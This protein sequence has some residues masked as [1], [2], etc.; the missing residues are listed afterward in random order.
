MKTENRFIGIFSQKFLA[1]LICCLLGTLFFVTNIQVVS[2]LSKNELPNYDESI[3]EYLKLNVSAND[4][5]AW[6][7]A[8]Q[9]SWEPWL[10]NQKGF[11]GREIFWDPGLEEAL[12]LI[13]WASRK[14][15]KSIPQSEIDDVQNLFEKI[16]K[17]STGKKFGNPFPIKSQGEFLPQ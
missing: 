12:L 6:L 15:W 7:I 9:N 8:E 5:E 10:E 17:E 1:F 13:R 11:L 2:A 4:R 14:D 3:I 16:A